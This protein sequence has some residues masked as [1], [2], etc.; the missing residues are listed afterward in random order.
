MN[1]D[2]KWRSHP[3]VS[4]TPRGD[5]YGHPSVTELYCLAICQKRDIRTL[6]DLRAADL[7]MLRE[8]YW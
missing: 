4:G 3:D 2:T 8:I 7:P 1:V 6:R 5:W